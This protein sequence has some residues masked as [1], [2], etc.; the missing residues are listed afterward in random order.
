[1]NV[2]NAN[3]FSNQNKATVVFIVVMGVLHVHQFKR[4]KNVAEKMR[5][6]Y[7]SLLSDI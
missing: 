1:M 3:K 5:T 6:K 2:K 7:L 4:I